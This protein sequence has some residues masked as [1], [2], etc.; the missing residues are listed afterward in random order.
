M[1]EAEFM[2]PDD[3]FDGSLDVGGNNAELSRFGAEVVIT[4]A[5]EIENL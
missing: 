2:L 4:S 5:D 1:I 3:F